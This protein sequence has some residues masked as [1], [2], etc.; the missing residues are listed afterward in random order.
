MS[1][2]LSQHNLPDILHV[3]GAP[4]D[5]PQVN[6]T[7]SKSLLNTS[8][9]SNGNTSNG[10]QQPPPVPP[11]NFEKSFDDDFMGYGQRNVQ[12]C[13]FILIFLTVYTFVTF[14]RNEPAPLPS[15]GTKLEGLLMDEFEEDFNPRAFETATNGLASHQSNNNALI[16]GQLSGLNFSQSNGTTS[17][18][19]LCKY[20]L[21]VN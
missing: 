19:P 3:P 1:A 15:V 9:D 4:T 6:G 20:S 16:N 11:R 8:S 2:Y 18:P 12:S 10:P 14:Y 7:T 17:P 13:P 21:Y 5:S